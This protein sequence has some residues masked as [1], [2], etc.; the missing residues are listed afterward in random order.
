M[1]PPPV[2]GVG[3]DHFVSPEL[4]LRGAGELPLAEDMAADVNTLAATVW[5]CATGASHVTTRP[6]SALCVVGRLRRLWKHQK[7]MGTIPALQLQG[8]RWARV[9]LAGG[10]S[11]WDE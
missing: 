3:I 9:A 4:A 8:L 11:T 2:T 1:R 7:G 5:T 10:R 6:R